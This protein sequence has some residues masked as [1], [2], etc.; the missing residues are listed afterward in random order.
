MICADFFVHVSFVL[1]LAL[2][3][4]S[5]AAERPNIVFILADDVGYGDLQCY[6]SKGKVPTPNLDNLSLPSHGI[7]GRC[8][9]DRSRDQ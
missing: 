3:V 5:F 4:S 9:M 6:N 7:L 1:A 2:A 8:A